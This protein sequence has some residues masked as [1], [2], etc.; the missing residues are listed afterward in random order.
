MQE[1]TW[2]MRSLRAAV[3]LRTKL[4]HLPFGDQG[5]LV[6]T[7]LFRSDCTLAAAALGNAAAPPAACKLH[8]RAGVHRAS[9]SKRLSNSNEEAPFANVGTY[10]RSV[11]AG[12]P[13][14]N[15]VAQAL[16]V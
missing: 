10:L 5:L 13:T 16:W 8:A 6:S 1:D 11:W 12:L 15:K 7:D 14:L 9:S 2:R 3:S 4:L